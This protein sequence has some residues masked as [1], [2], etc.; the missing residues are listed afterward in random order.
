MNIGILYNSFVC[1]VSG[2]SSLLVFLSLRR[3]RKKEKVNYSQNLDYFLLFLGLLW[4]SVGTRI[5][6]NWFNNL[7]L[8]NFFYQWF[9]GPLTYI[10]LV[11]AFYYFGWSFFS[12]KKIRTLFNAFFTFMSSLAVL[13]HFLY[14]FERPE[15]T[16]WGNNI[17]P[18]PLTNKIFIFGIFI[19]AIPCIIIETARR[20][21]KWRKTGDLA[22]RQLFGFSLGFLVYTITGFFEA[23]IF[24]QGW[25]IIIAR[26]CI[27]L[28]PLTFYLFSAFSLEEE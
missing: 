26:I 17:I 8:D 27:M 19:P 11:P 22:E 18:N 12:D 5:F 7:T 6:V 28:V 1:F 16:Y 25:Q 2:F 20:F 24:T 13:T 23:V 15:L 3:I 4:V 14:K 10:H 9:V 21:K